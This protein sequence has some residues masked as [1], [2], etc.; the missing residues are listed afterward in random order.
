MKKNLFISFPLVCCLIALSISACGSKA[1]D[2]ET[3]SESPLSAAASAAAESA[4]PITI[5]HA[6]GETVIES[7]PERVVAIAWG[8]GDVPL[9]LGVVPVGISEAN[10]GVTDG[11]NLLPWTK[12]R[13]EELGGS[14]T[15]VV[16]DD[17]DGFDFEAINECEPDVIL[18]ASSGMSQEEYETL[19]AIA[20][21][22][23]YPAGKA[24]QVSWREQILINA[25]AMGMEAEGEQLV[26]ERDKLLEEK[27]AAYPQLKGKTAAFAYINPADL[28]SI[29]F[30]TPTDTRGAFLTDLGF[31]FPASL[32]AIAESSD[33]FYVSLSAENVDILSDIDI[34]VA[35][36]LS[37]D[38]IE[39]TLADPLLGSIPALK[40]GGYCMIPEGPLSAAFSASVLSIP[41]SI[42]EI[43]SRIAEAA[44][45]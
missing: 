15:T 30:Y 6:F 14:E 21:T 44:D 3:V 37:D 32:Q 34:L 33:S 11:G 43:L 35:Y 29:S 31:E 45:Q 7:K 18:A 39:L 36:A 38:A 42:D 13:L 26:A 25:K 12:E 19:R 22:I 16:F 27:L 41:W 10:W 17:T 9:A 24:W 1:A 28:S 23:P 8:N 2:A 40:R 5:A 20:P 4:Y